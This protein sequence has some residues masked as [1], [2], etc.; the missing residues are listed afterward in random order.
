MAQDQFEAVTAAF[1][2]E[3][4]QYEVYPTKRL[5]ERAEA[6]GWW[7]PIAEW[8]RTR[9]KIGAYFDRILGDDQQHFWFGFYS[10]PARIR[11]LSEK[12]PKDLQNWAVVTDKDFLPNW[13]LNQQARGRIQRANG[14]VYEQYE[15]D[16]HYFGKYDIGFPLTP[17]E[18]LAVQAALFVGTIVEHIQ[19]DLEAADIEEIKR[20]KIDETTRKQLI[21]ARRGQGQFRQGLVEMWKGCS[22]T[23]CTVN[24]VLRASHIKPWRCSRDQERIDP[25][26]GLLLIATLDALFDRGL[27]SFDDGGQMLLSSKLDKEQI[28]VILY[29]GRQNLRKELSPNQ[30]RYLAGHRKEVFLA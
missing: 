23:G 5:R 17:G 10:T 30:K 12:V 18:R 1:S 6:Q 28:P 2:K 24:E 21:D 3:L 11:S 27:I 4:R 13:H 25:N 29:P 14:L 19:P 15:D 7:T 16:D 22:I 26:N 8:G 9:P 20:R